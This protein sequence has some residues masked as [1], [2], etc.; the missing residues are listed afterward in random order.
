[1]SQQNLFI[2]LTDF[3]LSWQDYKKQ[4]IL[5]FED[6]VRYYLARSSP[7]FPSSPSPS[8]PTTKSIPKI[9]VLNPPQSCFFPL[10]QIPFY[11]LKTLDFFHS[12]G[13]RKSSHEGLRGRWRREEEERKNRFL[14]FFLSLFQILSTPWK[15]WVLQLFLSAG[16]GKMWG[17]FLLPIPIVIAL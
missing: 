15:Y 13:E 6:L 12:S 11:L 17:C 2:L 3:N 5:T 16:W 14:F 4:I 9:T 8:F 7:F 1:M 10:F